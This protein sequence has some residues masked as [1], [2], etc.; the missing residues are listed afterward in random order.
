MIEPGRQGIVYQMSLGAP[1]DLAMILPLP[2]A[3]DPKEDSVSFV[4]LSGYPKFFD[5]LRAAFPVPITRS[6]GL[7][8]PAAGPPAQGLQVHEVGSYEAS[9]VPKLAD[10]KRL[11]DRFRLPDQ[12]WKDLPQFHD[13]GFAVFKLKEGEREIHPMAFTFPTRH[14]AKLFFPTVHIHDGKVHAKEEFDHDLY[15]Q[16]HKP[17]LF[18]MTRWEES[19]GHAGSTCN[20]ENSKGLLAGNQHLHRLTI[21]GIH[22]NEDVLLET[23]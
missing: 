23:A 14:P 10:F 16:V 20:I 19:S 13:H 5:H 18:A 15:C 1:A 6:R 7:P 2:V 17:G 3:A 9:F 22:Q 11:D 8:A 4:D 21:Y 12:V